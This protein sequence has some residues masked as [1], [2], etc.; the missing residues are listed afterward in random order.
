VIPLS[1]KKR[2]KF[3]NLLIIGNGYLI[4]RNKKNLKRFI[5][6]GREED[7]EFAL[8]VTGGE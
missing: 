7:L 3:D 6:R 5:Y 4:I 8:V 2:V 1:M